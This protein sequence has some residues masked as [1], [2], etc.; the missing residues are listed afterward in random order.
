MKTYAR[1]DERTI[2]YRG[3]LITRMF[4]GAFTIHRD[5][6]HISYAPTIEAAHAIINDLTED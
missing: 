5:G 2:A 1:P 3:Y 4:D 6:H